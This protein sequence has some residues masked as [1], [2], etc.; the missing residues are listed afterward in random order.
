MANKATVGRVAPVR[1]ITDYLR[2]FPKALIS[3]SHG[4]KIEPTM[5]NGE[6]VG[7]TVGGRPIGTGADGQL[8]EV[9]KLV[10]AIANQAL[11]N[12]VPPPAVPF[13]TALVPGQQLT[14]SFQLRS[15]PY[16]P[17][18]VQGFYALGFDGAGNLIQLDRD[19]G[20]H[21]ILCSIRI[22]SEQIWQGSLM[23]DQDDWYVFPLPV[24][25]GAGAQVEVTFTRFNVPTALPDPLYLAWG[26]FGIQRHFIPP[27]FLIDSS[28][29]PIRNQSTGFPV[30]TFP[31]Q[32]PQ[33]GFSQT[34]IAARFNNRHPTVFD[35]IWFGGNESTFFDMEWEAGE[36]S[37]SPVPT[38]LFRYRRQ[39]GQMPSPI[40]IN[41]PM[42]L[43]FNVYNWL[44]QE[45]TQSLNI[46]GA[47]YGY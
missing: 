37:P 7:A 1:N 41:A 3:D 25:A 43:N 9:P 2:A 38:A 8:L 4:Q 36:L 35:E 16:G 24:E 39:G 15:N 46:S 47:S 18:M 42:T 32:V 22:T 29:D 44:P 26:L 11:P 21:T 10:P 13:T 6:V 5:V 34:P 31:A 27:S 30:T 19:N 20:G 40:L 33:T 12:Q 28:L 23:I 14:F 17:M 45:I